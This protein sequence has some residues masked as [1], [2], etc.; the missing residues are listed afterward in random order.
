MSASE[1]SVIGGKG[2]GMGCCKYFMYGI[3]DKRR[4]ASCITAPKYKDYGGVSVVK[5]FNYV[6]GVYLPAHSFMTV[7]RGLPYGQ[8]GV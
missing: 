2:R 4:L 1:K 7:G 5:L 8:R 3:G 6:I